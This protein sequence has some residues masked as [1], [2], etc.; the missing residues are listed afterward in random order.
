MARKRSIKYRK[1]RKTRKIQKTRKTKKNRKNKKGGDEE[2]YESIVKELNKHKVKM[3]CHESDVCL[4]LGIFSDDIKGYFEGFTNFKYANGTIESIG[5]RSANGSVK[6]IEYKNEDYISHAILK[7]TL[8]ADADNLMYEYNVGQ[9]INKVNKQYPC[10]L[11]TY[12]L[13]KYNTDKP[14][15]ILEGLEQIEDT[16]DY[17]N[18]CINSNYL[19]ILI[20]Y[21][22]NV[23]TLSEF[24]S[25]RDFIKDDLMGILFQ[26]YIPLA[27]LKDTFTHYDLHLSNILIY[28][29]MP[30]KYIEYHYHLDKIIS[31]KSRYIAKIIDY[32]HSYYF[33]DENNNSKKIYDKVCKIEDCRPDCGI[34]KGFK[35]F[36]D[37]YD[38]T[39]HQHAYKKNESQDLRALNIL[40]QEKYFDVLPTDIK[41]IVENVRYGDRSTIEII[42]ENKSRFY[43]ERIEN[44]NDAKDAIIKKVNNS[45]FRHYNNSVYDGLE[46]FGD[47][48]VYEEK[49]MEFTIT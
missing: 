49:D 33:E 10:F 19:A 15:N 11:E 2:H 31:F 4:A 34:D 44:V 21:F 47:L 41:K 48:R 38:S 13:Y 24:L 42:N 18:A 20:Q 29:P 22:K 9:Y 27:K 40:K 14:V 39:G 1:T 28:E 17:G 35:Y 30:G 36:N 23:K 26:I 25:D 46:K 6:L 3:T 43:P 37:N 5:V 45:Q 12:G 32:G 16:N 7:S 8:R